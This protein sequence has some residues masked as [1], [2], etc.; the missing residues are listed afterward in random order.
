MEREY[1][2]KKAYLYRTDG[3]VY[4]EGSSYSSDMQSEFGLDEDD[5]ARPEP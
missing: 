2:N 1:I 3:V 4:C 5:W